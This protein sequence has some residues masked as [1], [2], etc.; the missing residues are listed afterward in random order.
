M[1]QAR[2]RQIKFSELIFLFRKQ[3]V[4]IATGLKIIGHRN[5]DN[6]LESPC[7]FSYISY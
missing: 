3:F 6:N 7:T 1:R 4:S 2:R 5:P